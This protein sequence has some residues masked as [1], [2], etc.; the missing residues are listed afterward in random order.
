MKT[1]HD[2]IMELCAAREAKEE[3]K[4]HRK[5]VLEE[6]WIIE[7][8]KWEERTKN[9]E[10]YQIYPLENG[11]QYG[12]PRAREAHRAYTEAAYKHRV[13]M[14]AINRYWNENR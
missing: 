11:V 10:S 13:A 4:K 7:R 5:E 1:A 9:S 3:A 8:D 6:E 2:L 14:R 12:N